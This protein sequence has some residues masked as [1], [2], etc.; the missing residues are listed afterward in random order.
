[1]SISFLN[2]PPVK[3]YFLKCVSEI[4]Y[5]LQKLEDTFKVRVKNEVNELLKLC[6]CYLLKVR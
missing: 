4:S 2:V 1:M 3:I 5:Y 6:K